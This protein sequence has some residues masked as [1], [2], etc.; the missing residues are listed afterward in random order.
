[1]CLLKHF[2]QE[3]IHFLECIHCLL[4]LYV[5]IYLIVINQELLLVATMSHLEVAKTTG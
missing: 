4:Q 2:F 5:L 1:M 3:S